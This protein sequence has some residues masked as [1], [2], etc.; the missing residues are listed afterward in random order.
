[1]SEAGD[2][3]KAMRASDPQTEEGYN[4]LLQLQRGTLYDLAGF[5]NLGITTRTVK[6]DLLAEIIYIYVEKGSM[7]SN[8]LESIEQLKVTKPAALNV[9]QHKADMEKLKVEAQLI[10]TESAVRIAESEAE[11]ARVRA[12]G[13]MEA[14]RIHAESEARIA[15]L[16]EE[17]QLVDAAQS[18]AP[19]NGRTTAGNS[20]QGSEVTRQARF[21][22]A[23]NEKE[24]DA[25]FAHFEI[26]AK[27]L[28][29]PE[30]SWAPMLLSALK[31]K[32]QI[33]CTN[34]SLED[35]RCMIC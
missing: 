24:I 23:W 12:A 14:Q 9:G 31:G 32:A 10:K 19:G 35:G 28:K 20:P 17:A 7:A 13:E 21:V 8:K 5:L 15:I 26:V 25:Y 11:T 34:L 1:M 3:D 29:W 27:T 30:D 6:G 4:A 18:S 16:R 22:P 33:A 2:F